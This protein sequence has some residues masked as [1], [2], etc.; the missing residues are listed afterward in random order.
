MAISGPGRD[1]CDDRPAEDGR[2]RAAKTEYLFSINSGTL[3]LDSGDE[4][5]A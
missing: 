4:I 1:G 5:H 3:T 2:N